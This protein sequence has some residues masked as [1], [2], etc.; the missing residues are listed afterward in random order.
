[1]KQIQIL[2][3]IQFFSFVLCLSIIAYHKSNNNSDI[4]TDSKNTLNH[5]PIKAIKPEQDKRFTSSK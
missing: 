2:K 5:L 1:M 4:M 3:M